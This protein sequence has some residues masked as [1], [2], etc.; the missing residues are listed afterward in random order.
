MPEVRGILRWIWMVVFYYGVKSN[1]YG[2]L[3]LFFGLWI[4]ISD[5]YSLNP[6]GIYFYSLSCNYLSYGSSKD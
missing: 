1:L 2:V 6:V 5:D 4:Y 3:N